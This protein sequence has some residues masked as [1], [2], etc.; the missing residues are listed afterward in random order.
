MEFPL[1]PQPDFMLTT[2]PH[3]PQD[4]GEIYV[5][6]MES[7]QPLNRQRLCGIRGKPQGPKRAVA[8]PKF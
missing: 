5:R 3:L 8:L 6:Q 2:F 7:V 4:F 1:S